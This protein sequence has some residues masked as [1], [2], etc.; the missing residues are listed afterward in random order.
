MSST[1][2]PS[3][4]FEWARHR[5]RGELLDLVLEVEDRLRRL[6]RRVLQDACGEE[7][8]AAWEVL[9]A[10]RIR[11]EIVQWKT[12]SDA[13]DML[14]R[15]NLGQLIGIV[16]NRWDLFEGLMADRAAFQAN[17]DQFRGWRNALAHGKQ[18]SENE[19]V[20]IAFLAGRIGRHISAPIET[21]FHGGRTVHGA[22]VLWVD[23]LPQG[24]LRE[25]RILRMLG[26]E[27]V[28]VLSND[29]AVEVARERPFDVIIS[30]IGRFGHDSGEV[31]PARMREVGV[32]APIVFYVGEVVTHLGT[33]AGAHSIRDDPALLVLDTITL[34]SRRTRATA[35]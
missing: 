21:M 31:L 33:P 6:V 8:P 34:L 29:E 10:D 15:A 4:H 26:I 14:D 7:Q 22:S 27:V 20:E 35:D 9:I 24:N 1:R 18:P 3:K 12:S 11:A 28:P 32:R 25:R 13:A 5:S 23:D 2:D 30:D 16:L 19:K 17:A